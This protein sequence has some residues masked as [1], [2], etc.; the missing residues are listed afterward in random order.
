MKQP[1]QEVGGPHQQ[2]LGSTDR[3]PLI[4]SS[5]CDRGYTNRPKGKINDCIGYHIINQACYINNTTM[6]MHFDSGETIGINL[7][8]QPLTHMHRQGTYLC[9]VKKRFIHTL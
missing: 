6:C 7:Q 9:V 5:L 8:E 4:L 3:L 1:D 2:W